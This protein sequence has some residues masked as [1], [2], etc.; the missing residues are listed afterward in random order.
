MARP[1]RTISYSCPTA[2]RLLRSVE[3][4]KT[5][6]S[7]RTVTIPAWLGEELAFHLR[8]HDTQYVFTAP[9]GGPLRRSGFRSRVWVPAT[10]RADLTGV[11][12]HD[13]RHTHAAWLVEAGK[14]P[15]V[16]QARLGHASITTTLNTYGHLMPGLDEDAAEAL[17]PL[18]APSPRP[19]VVELHP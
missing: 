1:F 17:P 14:H 4:P 13:L 18:P 19:E 2:P 10:V 8:G 9:R 6:A 7:R 16:I 11:R 5:P 12:F 15:K 3:E